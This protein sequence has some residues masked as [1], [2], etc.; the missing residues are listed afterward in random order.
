MSYLFFQLQRVGKR[1]KCLP[2]SDINLLTFLGLGLGGEGTG[3]GVLTSFVLKEGI[4]F[5]KL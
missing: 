1:K 4:L 5:L 3:A 2:Y